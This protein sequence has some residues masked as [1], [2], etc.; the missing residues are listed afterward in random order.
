MIEI[1]IDGNAA[2][3]TAGR[4]KYEAYKYFKDNKISMKDYAHQIENDSWLSEEEKIVIPE[5]FD[6]GAD[7]LHECYDLWSYGGPRLDDES[8]MTVLDDDSET[9][10]ESNLDLEVL[11]NAGV[12]LIKKKSS[13][14]V[15]ASLEPGEAAVY[16][17]RYEEGNVFKA[18]VEEAIDFD[19]SKLTI[20]Y[21]EDDEG[22]CYASEIIYEDFDVSNDWGGGTV[23]GSF[24]SLFANE[25]DETNKTDDS[26]TS[27]ALDNENSV[28]ITEPSMVIRIS[29]AYREDVTPQELYDVTRSAWKV[30]LDRANTIDYA[31]AVY[32]GEIKEVYKV[33]GWH[34]AG[35]TFVPVR[36]DII[37]SG[38]FEF[39]GTVAEDAIRD[40]YLNKSVKHMF[41]KG[42]VIPTMYVNC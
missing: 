13:D 35:T 30:N 5:E 4:I 14:D 33:A 17:S 38:R 32:K 40:K 22:V 12:T 21:H 15:L 1:S 28:E 25:A 20:Y 26:S 34:E 16:G 37:G 19:P 36:E 2:E 9:L 6:F 23:W 27:T 41:K 10:W 31:F 18:E 24:Y 11:K 8:Y 39:V 29:Q 7:G 3:G 42:A